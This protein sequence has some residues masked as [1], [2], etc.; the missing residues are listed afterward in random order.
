MTNYEIPTLERTI[1]GRRTMRSIADSIEALRN[2]GR[3]PEDSQ[4]EVRTGPLPALTDVRPSVVL[5]VCRAT[6]APT[7]GVA[8][9]TAYEFTGKR[10]GANAPETFDISLLD[11][12]QVE[13]EGE[14]LLSNGIRLRAVDIVPAALPWELTERQ[15]RI[16]YWTIQFIGAEEK[17]FVGGRATADLEWVDYRALHNLEVPKL[18]AI[19]AHIAAN[20]PRLRVSRQTIATALGVSGMRVPRQRPRA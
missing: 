17:C 1:E 7:W 13:L 8:L 5:V 19:V 12:A 2:A 18:E 9:P 4:L 10:L 3:L 14:V 11:R 6:N 20:D 16:V 15:K